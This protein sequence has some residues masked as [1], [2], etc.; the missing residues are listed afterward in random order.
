M[1]VAIG[2]ECLPALLVAAAG[3]DSAVRQRHEFADDL[4]AHGGTGKLM[5]RI[6]PGTLDIGDPYASQ[7]VHIPS[8]PADTKTVALFPFPI[9]ADGS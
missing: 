5:I 3:V 2:M 6:A 9:A 7:C 4:E 1:W 8:C